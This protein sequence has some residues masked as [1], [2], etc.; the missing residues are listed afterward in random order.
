M[1]MKKIR[2]ENQGVDCSEWGVDSVIEIELSDSKKAFVIDGVLDGDLSSLLFRN[3]SVLPYKFVDFDRDDTNIQHLV[4][5][6]GEEE[7]QD[8]QGA[9]AMVNLVF[10]LLDALKL[11]HQRSINRAYINFNLFGDFQY[12]HDDGD[13][14]TA[15]FF[16][17]DRWEEDWMGE[18]FIVDPVDGVKFAITPKP[19]RMVLFDGKILHRGGVPSKMCF[20][21]RMTL[22]V[23]VSR[24]ST[25]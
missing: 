13:E 8:P 19:G 6:V 20:K 15:L 2:Y 12:A 1:A 25:G 24:L 10:D 7:I 21:P 18:F 11:P 23:K 5:Y 22:A 16:I 14:W 4:H 9:G 3:Y 17:A